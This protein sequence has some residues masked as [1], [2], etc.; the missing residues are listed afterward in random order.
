MNDILE[1]LIAGFER[2]NDFEL[3]EDEKNMIGMIALE[4]HSEK[5]K[6]DKAFDEM[7]SVDQKYL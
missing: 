2:D 5:V 7:A 6:Q 3:D 1:R 4:Y